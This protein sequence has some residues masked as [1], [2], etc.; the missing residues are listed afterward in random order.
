MIKQNKG[1][2]AQPQNLSN[3][4][5]AFS[6]CGVYDLPLLQAISSAS[7]ANIRAFDT[8][9]L[10]TLAWAFAVFG[11]GIVPAQASLSAGST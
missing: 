8:Q 10:S 1:E 2:A 5:W 9:N 4:A 11:I 7:I 6:A 3:L